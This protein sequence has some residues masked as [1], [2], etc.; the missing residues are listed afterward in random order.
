MHSVVASAAVWIVI[1][2]VVL[3]VFFLQY[4]K[5]TEEY[6]ANQCFSFQMEIMRPFVIVLNYTAITVILLVVCILLV[7]Q[8]FIIV[9]ILKKLKHAALDHQE[10]WVQLKSLFFILI[11]IICFFPH[12]IFRIYYIHHINDCFYY[13]EIFLALTALSCLDLLSF[14]VQTYFQKVFK[15]I[16]CSLRC[17]CRSLC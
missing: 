17:P 7:V 5:K 2:L 16:T 14:A 9:K 1:L 4:G 12:H 8:T 10:F 3:P 6:K 15:H 11:M 13:N